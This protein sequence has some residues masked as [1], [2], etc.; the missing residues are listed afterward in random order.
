[1]KD[2]GGQGGGGRV[3][4]WGSR[5]D[6]GLRS[7]VQG[8]PDAVGT[9]ERLGAVDLRRPVY[10]LNGPSPDGIES[11][12]RVNVHLPSLVSRLQYGGSGYHLLPPLADGVG[13][14]LPARLC[15]RSHAGTTVNLPSRAACSHLGH[16]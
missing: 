1:M 11:Y 10:N 9:A 12:D 16:L 14:A 2:L 8:S 15:H 6:D 13:D 7:R 4:G 5:D 3:G